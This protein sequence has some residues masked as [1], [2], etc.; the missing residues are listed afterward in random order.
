MNK[1]PIFARHT[2]YEM[3][4][5]IGQIQER[6]PGCYLQENPEPA[7]T[8]TI[9]PDRFS[10]SYAAAAYAEAKFDTKV[11]MIIC[12]MQE[13]WPAMFKALDSREKECQQSSS[14]LYFLELLT[15]EELTEYMHA[16]TGNKE[17][18]FYLVTLRDLF[19]KY[20]NCDIDGTLFLDQCLQAFDG[21]L[22]CVCEDAMYYRMISLGCK[23]LVRHQFPNLITKTGYVPTAMKIF[24]LGTVDTAAEA[25]EWNQEYTG[26]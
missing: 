23:T 14:A 12:E 7:K 9:N 6:I 17:D 18:L 2:P 10:A 5:L 13:M 15:T 20:Y 8:F 11:R 4:Q 1:H 24:G 3:F 21:L 16:A 25:L 22:N 19:E 26:Y